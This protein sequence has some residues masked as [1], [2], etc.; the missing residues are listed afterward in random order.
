MADK[1]FNK[2]NFLDAHMERMR[3]IINKRNNPEQPQQKMP[4]LT[5][6]RDM[7]ARQSKPTMRKSK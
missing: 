6:L 5:R 7:E 2:K 4:M 1:G 3:G